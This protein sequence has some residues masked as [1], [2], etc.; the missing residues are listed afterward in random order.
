M[1]CKECKKRFTP[2]HGL[3]KYCSKKCTKKVRKK[4]LKKY[5]QSDKGKSSRKKYSLT[6]KGKKSINKYQKSDKRK[7]VL[8]KYNQS[9]KGKI[10]SRKYN[11]SDKRR[12]TVRNY[13]ATPEGKKIVQKRNYRYSKSEKGKSNKRRYVK[14]KYNSDAIFKLRRIVRRRLNHFL[15]IRQM[16]KTNTTFLMVKCNPEFLKK[17]LEKQFLPGMTWRNNT[18]NGW[19][20][21]HIVPL[22]SAEN[23]KDVERLMHYSNL[24]P[25][26]ATENLKK[27]NKII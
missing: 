24:Q 8:K 11:Q 5:N 21:D 17:H 10:T 1:L 23:P 9:A 13:Y 25:M 2:S 7:K 26:W 4:A 19:H 15:E 3:Q 16:R 12:S 27:G 22:S 6:N 18:K 20:V 14:K